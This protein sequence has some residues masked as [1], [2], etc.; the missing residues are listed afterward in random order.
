MTQ[1][2]RTH[3]KPTAPLPSGD[4]LSAL[5]SDPRIA[6]LIEAA[7]AAKVAQLTDGVPEASGHQGELVGA[8]VQALD[9]HSQSQAYQQPGYQKPLP[10]EEI[11]R[12]AAAYVQMGALITQAISTGDRP[13]YLLL[14]DFHCDEI[15]W[16]KGETIFWEGPPNIQM[17]PRNPVAKAIMEQMTAWIGGDQ[18]PIEDQVAQAWANRPKTMP[19]EQP[20]P[21]PAMFRP[22]RTTAQSRV[23][24][25][26][27]VQHQQ[28]GTNRIVGTV[29]PEF[30]S[31]VG[32]NNVGRPMPE[33]SGRVGTV[34]PYEAPA[35]PGS[36]QW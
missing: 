11:E 25:V 3:R 30:Q 34:Q 8:L 23:E 27:G 24:A 5:L 6:T 18:V 28:I 9:R 4:P 7:V 36:T 13:M 1:W 32:M 22:P 19:G 21:E 29:Q 15:L 20:M 35:T 26:P 33:G 14:D 10:V 16:P 31:R 17:E 2:Q 12:R